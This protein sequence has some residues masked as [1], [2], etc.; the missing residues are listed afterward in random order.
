LLGNIYTS[1]RAYEKENNTV[2]YRTNKRFLYSGMKKDKKIP[3]VIS[4]RDFFYKAG[5]KPTPAFFT[6]QSI[7]F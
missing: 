4:G 2:S 3:A 6:T 5:F 1:E 7:S